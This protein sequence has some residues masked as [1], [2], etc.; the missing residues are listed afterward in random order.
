MKAIFFD[1]DGVLADSFEMYSTKWE[2]LGKKYDA[3]VPTKESFRSL[4]DN[5]FY[6]SI[7]DRYPHLSSNSEIFKE[8][9]RLTLEL[10]GKVKLFPKS[11]EIIKEL[12]KKY[13]LFIITSTYQ[14]AV[15][16]ALEKHKLTDKFVEILGPEAALSKV[17][18]FNYAMKKYNLKK[19]DII[20]VTDTLGD[21]K[22]ANKVG[23]NTIAVSWGYQHKDTLKKGKPYKIFDKIT[24]LKEI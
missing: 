6:D 11:D 9:V 20:F 5:N 19:D 17:D 7:I 21:I 3:P 23:L 1:F 15:L 14:E 24:Q 10:A 18:K 8:S 13:K 16:K 2:T 22:E 4:F 12:S